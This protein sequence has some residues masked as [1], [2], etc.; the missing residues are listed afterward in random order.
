MGSALVIPFVFLSISTFLSPGVTLRSRSD[1]TSLVPPSIT[2]NF[3]G[4]ANPLPREDIPM[5]LNTTSGSICITCGY[6]AEGESVGSD[7]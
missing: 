7:G 6:N 5:D 4:K 3:G 2:T 1:T